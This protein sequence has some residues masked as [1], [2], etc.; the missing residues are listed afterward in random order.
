MTFKKTEGTIAE[1]RD[2]FTVYSTGAQ[3]SSDVDHLRFDL[4]PPCALEELAEVYAEGSIAHG[5]NNWKKGM[6]DSVILNHAI[7]H[8]L[9]YMEGD[10][11]ELHCGKVM[12][13]MA[14]LIWNRE[15]GS[16]ETH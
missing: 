8:L 14:A 13:G 1:E 7:A 15:V 12:W 10:R 2:G 3:R 4:I 16:E 9:K 11:S 6:P 5:D